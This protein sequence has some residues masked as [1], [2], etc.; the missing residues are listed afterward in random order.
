MVIGQ[1]VLQDSGG[2]LAALQ[3]VV[4]VVEAPVTVGGAADAQSGAIGAVT[5]QVRQLGQ[6]GLGKGAF[7]DQVLGLVTGDEH[8]CQRHQ[9]GASGLAFLPR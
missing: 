9:I 8:L 2:D 7:H 6:S 4:G 5:R 3:D 1:F